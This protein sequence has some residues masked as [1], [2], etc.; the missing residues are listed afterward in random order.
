MR[1]I[2]LSFQN[3]KKNYRPEVVNC[4]SWTQLEESANFGL[5][6]WRLRSEIAIGLT[7]RVCLGVLT[8]AVYRVS[9]L[10]AGTAWCLITLQGWFTLCGHCKLTQFTGEHT[11]RVLIS[12]SCSVMP[13]D[14][15]AYLKR[16]QLPFLS[17]A[18]QY[19]WGHASGVDF[20]LAQKTRNDPGTL[21]T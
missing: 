8:R 1:Q 16:L 13:E 18:E 2:L 15:T 20:Q 19:N 4:V 6:I 10:I 11:E 9:S 5:M 17:F 14:M 7:S 21:D 12:L 3:L